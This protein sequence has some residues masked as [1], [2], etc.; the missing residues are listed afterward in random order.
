MSVLREEHKA[1][2]LWFGNRFGGFQE[3]KED[4]EPQVVD[5]PELSVCL[6]A[7]VYNYLAYHLL[8]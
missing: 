2:A 3:M 7:L 5:I 1:R 8:F 4:E 6:I